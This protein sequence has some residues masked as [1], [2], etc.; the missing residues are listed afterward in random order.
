MRALG[1][2]VVWTRLLSLLLGATVYTFSI[3]LAVFLCGLWGGSSAG[4]V[5]ARTVRDPRLALA[6][7]QILLA[8]AIAWTAFTIAHSLPYWPVDPWLSLD[9]WFNFQL[10]LVRCV[11]A[12][13]PG[14]V[15][16]GASFPLALAAA[17]RSGEDPG[18]LSGEI[19][20]ANTAGSIVGALFFQPVA[21]SGAR[22]AG[23]A[24]VADRAV[25]GGR[26]GGWRGGFRRKRGAQRRASA[27]R[28][29]VARLLVATV[30]G[31]SVASDRVWAAHCSDYPRGSICTNDVPTKVLFR[32]E[33]INSSVLIAERAGQRHFYVS[34]KAEASTA[35]LDMRLERMMGHIPA[36]IHPSR[37]R[38]WWWDLARG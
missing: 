3:I 30:Y 36:L 26:C 33:G 13:F 6:V 23:I 16:W 9:P 7:C 32:G 38:C 28:W 22:D 15:L 27:A 31:C 34:G 24:T 14:T 10:D 12:I 2:E 18:R 11:W 19:Y 1:A 35:P 4:S 25:R 21:D 8:A 20:A 29:R 17:A 5:L 37:A